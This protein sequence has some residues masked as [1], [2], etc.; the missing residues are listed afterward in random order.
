MAIDK[1]KPYKILVTG[2]SVSGKTSLA[3]QLE[4]D[5]NNHSVLIEN[6]DVDW[7]KD[8]LIISQGLEAY[9]LQTPK[10]CEIEK[11]HKISPND[12]HKI[13]YSDPDL[14]TYIEFL[15]S[16]ACAWF[17]EGVVERGLDFDPV[18]YSLEKL[19]RIIRRAT[20][21]AAS[22]EEFKKEDERYFDRFKS[23]TRIIIPEIIDSGRLFF[24]NY[25]TALEEILSEVKNGN[26]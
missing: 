14:E 11:A 22:R 26:L 6:K 17:K 20:K 10:G 9:I 21:Y 12:F 1:N 16:R 13:L 23:K 7:D 2:L 15:T 19:P 8:A 25:N 18:P 4:K 24:K 3:S 5:F